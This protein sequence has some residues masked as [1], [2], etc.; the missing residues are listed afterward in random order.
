MARRLSKEGYA[1]VARMRREWTQSLPKRWR[2]AMA[3][4]VSDG[5]EQVA[6]L[7]RQLVPVDSGDLRDSIGT[8]Q[9]LDGMKAYVIAGDTGNDADVAAITRGRSA[10]A[11][12]AFYGVLVEYGTR[13]RPATPFFWSAWRA[14]VPQLRRKFSRAFARAFRKGEI[15]RPLG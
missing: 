13:N 8:F 7:Q 12:K 9:T 10:K 11:R 1:S 2:Q 15:A 6:D 3:E 4:A 14:M 5:A